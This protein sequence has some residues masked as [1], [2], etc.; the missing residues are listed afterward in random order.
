MSKLKSWFGTHGNGLI[1]V[2]IVSTLF[3]LINSLVLIVALGYSERKEMKQYGLESNL[4]KNEM[5]ENDQKLFLDRM[6]DSRKSCWV[7]T[8]YD[9][10]KLGY[11]TFYNTGGEKIVTDTGTFLIVIDQD[12]KNSDFRV[13]PSATDIISGLAESSGEPKK[14]INDERFISYII[15]YAKDK[16]AYTSKNS[17]NDGSSKEYLIKFDDIHYERFLASTADWDSSNEFFDTYGL[18]KRLYD[19]EKYNIWVVLNSND[20]GVGYA[21]YLENYYS[22]SMI[23]MYEKAY[24]VSNWKLGD[25]W[26]IEGNSLEEKKDILMESLKP[27]SKGLNEGVVSDLEE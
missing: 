12:K 25:D 5:P 2:L 20:T 13:K 7:A 24:R 16:G 15:D 11:Q 6:G 14:V 22:V 9:A 23:Y 18:N 3:M 17:N 8:S 19:K 4:N 21:V 1:L 10:N 27:I 26:Y